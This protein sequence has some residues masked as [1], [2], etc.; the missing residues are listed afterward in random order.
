MFKETPRDDSRTVFLGHI[1]IGYPG[2]ERW[3]IK[4]ISD[5]RPRW[6]PRG[7]REAPSPSVITKGQDGI[8]K[9]EEGEDT[10]RSDERG[11]HL[12]TGP[13]DKDK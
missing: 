6:R 1:R 13:P 3:N 8:E 7:V 10:D 4:Q 2:R 12:E 9:C 11:R 5:D